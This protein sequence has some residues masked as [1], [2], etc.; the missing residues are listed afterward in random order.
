MS[1]SL[2]PKGVPHTFRVTSAQPARLL[3]IHADDSFLGL[4]QSLGE[5]ATAH[6]L[7]RHQVDVDVETIERATQEHD[8]R[9]LG[10]S[11][12]EAEAQDVLAGWANA[13]PATD[14]VEA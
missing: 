12:D 8:S 11:F 1:S 7:P 9:I 3:L 4:V 5:P 6:E 13:R 14:G 10:P 2:L